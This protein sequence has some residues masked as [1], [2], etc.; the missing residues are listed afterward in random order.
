MMVRGDNTNTAFN[1][2]LNGTGFGE[3]SFVAHHANS[4]VA[5]NAD[6]AHF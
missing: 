2:C 6:L 1:N 3:Q 5:D 4:H